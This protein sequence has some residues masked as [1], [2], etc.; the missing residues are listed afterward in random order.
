[1][2]RHHAPALR[3]QV[4]DVGGND[5]GMAWPLFGQH[6]YAFQNA[7]HAGTQR[8][9][10]AHL[11]RLNANGAIGKHGVKHTAYGGRSDQPRAAGVYANN[12]VFITPASHEFFDIPFSQRVVKRRFGL[13]GVT[14]GGKR[15]FGLSH[16][17]NRVQL[18][19]GRE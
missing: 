9:Q 7:V 3:R 2:M 8:L 1:M 16:E 11:E 6:F 13:V 18:V 17:A 14:G 4:V 19:K 12:L 15:C 5:I 10:P